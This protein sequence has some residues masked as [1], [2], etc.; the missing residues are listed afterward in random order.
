MI[1]KQ[2]RL[3]KCISRCQPAELLNRA[4]SFFKY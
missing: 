1:D 4:H 3:A 2:F